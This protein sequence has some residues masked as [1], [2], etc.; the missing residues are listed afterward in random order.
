MRKY[1]WLVIVM[2][3]G[4]I[5]AFASCRRMEEMMAPVLPDAEQ[6]EPP[7]EMVES[8]P[9]LGD[10][11]IL[12]NS[13]I[14][15]EARVV[16][17]M[18][19]ET[20]NSPTAPRI[21]GNLR[22]IIVAVGGTM[23]LP[24]E[25]SGANTLGGCIVYIPGVGAYYE[26]PYGGAPDDLPSAI[27][28]GLSEDV[29]PGTF[30]EV[31]YGVYDNQGQTSNF[32]NTTVTVGTPAETLPNEGIGIFSTDLL[33][34]HGLL[35]E[36]FYPGV[37]LTMLPDFDTLTPFHTW[38]VANIDV[39][40]RSYTQG[41][42][43][44]GVDVL[45]DFA[46]RL[47]GQ[48]ET[49]T[50]GTYNFTISSD[51]GSKLLINGELLIDNDGLHGMSAKSN[52]I[53]L[54][55]G[56]HDVEIQYFQG[57]RTHIGLQWF[58]EPPG[59]AAAIVPPE[60]LYPPRVEETP[61]EPIV[62]MEMPQPSV[63]DFTDPDMHLYFSFD[64][65]DGNQAIDHSRYENHG[66]LVG[67]PQLVEGKF[68]KALEFNGVS[69][70]VEVPHDESLIVET[71]FTIMAWIKTPRFTTP[72]TSWQGIIA[73]GNN[74]RSYSFYTIETGLHLSVGV[75]PW[76]GSGVDKT[77]ELNQWQHVVAQVD[78]DGTHHYWVNGKLINSIPLDPVLPGS[79]DAA[80]IL[81]GRTH[82]SNR[83]FLGVID[84]LRLWRRV[85]SEDEILEHMAQGFH[86]E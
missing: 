21:D 34:G 7:P 46:I 3:I 43:E 56:F 65:L 8:I 18:R 86:A 85:L 9:E 23:D 40:V 68:G 39:P 76:E 37:K 78:V 22:E 14:I 51:D 62:E 45:E 11:S 59:A 6:I 82:E 74:P 2:L 38:M 72:G 1:Q 70:W 47:R 16:N 17:T 66:M 83:E 19:P 12:T 64:E 54:T 10:P 81:I 63:V 26:I 33:P 35:A 49:E 75:S 44:L 27:S 36:A 25:Y 48:I 69:D 31:C 28:V 42:P 52:S 20:S 80:S 50:A 13:L 15:A 4:C 32:L 77:L 73:K 24:F 30:I 29:S 79:R 41:F 67:N 84:E 71:G 60:A 53:M 61:A 55:A 58:W 57:P 5:I